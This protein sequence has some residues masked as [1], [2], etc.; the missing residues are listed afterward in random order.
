MLRWT[1]GSSCPTAMTK[2]HELKAGRWL[3]GGNGDPLGDRWCQGGMDEHSQPPGARTK[4]GRLVGTELADLKECFTWNKDAK[5]WCCG[6]YTS[7]AW[8]KLRVS[9][10][11]WVCSSSL[12]GLHE[13]KHI[14]ANRGR[15]GQPTRNALSTTQSP[16]WKTPEWQTRKKLF[17]VEAGGVR[18]G[19]FW[20]DWA[21]TNN[22]EFS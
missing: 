19:E 20:K 7:R 5:Q 17:G 21:E 10:D 2:A 9:L 12:W 8:K 22:T 6:N 13:S 18:I 11:P 3:R 14:D 1:I 16:N 15:Q 4:A